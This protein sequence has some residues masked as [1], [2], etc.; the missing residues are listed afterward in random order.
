MRE[1]DLTLKPEKCSFGLRKIKLLGHVVDSDGIK[2]D[3][4]KIVAVKNFKIPINLTGIRSF[5]G[6]A[7][8]YRRFILDFSI[9]ASPLSHLTKKNVKF[10]WGEEQ[11]KAFNLL[12]GKLCDFPVLI[13]F[14]PEKP[15]ELRCD[16][17][18][19]GLGSAL[20]HLTDEGPRVIQYASR[21][22]SDCEKKYSTTE[23]EC[24]AVVWA[25]E[26][27]KQYLNGLTFNV[28]TDHCAL[29]WL[30]T[31]STLPGRLCRW[32]L[33]LQPYQFKV[34]Y[35]SGKL[36]KDADCLS[37]FPIEEKPIKQEVA[38]LDLVLFNVER[39]ESF[40]EHQSG[41][42]FIKYIWQGLRNKREV[43]AIEE[44]E[45][46]SFCELNGTLFKRIDLLNSKKLVMV[47]PN[48]LIPDMIY[49]CHDDA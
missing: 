17:S 48:I 3:P 30:R 19:Y 38:D 14:D 16:A 37:R 11:D 41:D 15:V 39:Q 5:L 40:V 12:K 32:A 6:L 10:E 35:K 25:I 47:V 43:K 49:S 31:K 45:L 9:L 27:F 33:Q 26:K 21:L 34:V 28:V 42:S 20:L 4:D 22:M 13:H 7:G 8:Y 44:K 23:K 1:A 46:S 24:L 2:M 29:C 36:H 18:G